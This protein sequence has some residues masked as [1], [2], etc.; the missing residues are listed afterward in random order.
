METLVNE[1]IKY[2]LEE[3][4]HPIIDMP[5]SYVNKRELL[6][7]LINVRPA[8][9]LDEEIIKKEDMLLQSELKEKNIK[10][11][12]D[13]TDRLSIWQGSITEIK[14]GAIVNFA[15]PKLTGCFKPNHNCIDN[16]IHSNAGIALRLKC[17][18]IS[19][20]NDIEVSKVVLTEGYN[21]PCEYIIHTVKPNIDDINEEIIEEIKDCII[22]SLDL[23][24]NNNI[25]TICIPNLTVKTEDKDIVA[26]VIMNTIKDYLKDD[27]FFKKVVLN[28]LT[29]DSYNI[30]SKYI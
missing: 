7:G 1:L 22:N 8:T 18:E 23:A 10:D 20:G 21:L 12:N 30:Y 26:K 6:R 5:S 24:K 16:N 11:V 9:Y 29:L 3:K 15:T 25:D 19:K 13:F 28:V 17:K 14:V 2:F 27:T 4:E